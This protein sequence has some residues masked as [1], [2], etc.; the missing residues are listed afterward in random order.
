MS[1]WKTRHYTSDRGGQPTANSKS[2]VQ[3]QRRTD[4]QVSWVGNA[5][6][7]VGDDWQSVVAV[8]TSDVRG[9]RNTISQVLRGFVLLTPAHCCKGLWWWR[10]S[11]TA[12]RQSQCDILVVVDYCKLGSDI[13]MW[14]LPWLKILNT[15][16]LHSCNF[17]IRMLYKIDYSLFLLIQNTLDVL[18][19]LRPIVND[20]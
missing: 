12:G 11:R 2:L 3:R 17:V 18:S 19:L 8:Y 9:W 10:Q 16:K 6:Q 5:A 14:L 4:D 15:T 20:I 13:L 1:V 7:E